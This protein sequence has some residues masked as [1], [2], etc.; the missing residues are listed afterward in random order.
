MVGGTAAAQASFLG[1]GQVQDGLTGHKVI[2]HRHDRG[3]MGGPGT[4]KNWIS[5]PTQKPIFVPSRCAPNLHLTA[6]GVLRGLWGTLITAE[7][8][9]LA[10]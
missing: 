3:T 7:R 6:Y 1:T 4:L 8:F 10:T 2:P 9:G 5:L